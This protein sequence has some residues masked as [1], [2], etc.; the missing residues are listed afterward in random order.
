MATIF[1]NSHRAGAYKTD[2]W[3]HIFSQWYISGTPFVGRTMPHDISEY[4]SIADLQTLVMNQSFRLR[5]QFMMYMKALVF[6]KG[7]HRDG[8][9]NIAK[10]IMET[11]DAVLIKALGR[12]VTGYDENTWTNCRFKIV[13]NGNYLEFTQN[14]Q[15]K[16]ILLATGNR[17]IAEASPKDRIWGI[18]FNIGDAQ[19]TPKDKWGTN[20]LGK[21]IMEVRTLLKQL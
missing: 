6:A 3:R 4:I 7:E 14:K 11:N 19:R 16:D 21:A 20:L 13:V 9:L 15:M 2:S 18:G 12:K 10:Q 17:E 1:F 8:N 5:E